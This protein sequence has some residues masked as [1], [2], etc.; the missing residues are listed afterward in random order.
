[1]FP[2]RVG[3]AR[4]K[5]RLVAVFAIALVAVR[6]APA[7]AGA[8]V[9]IGGT[10]GFPYYPYPGYGYYPYPYAYPYPYPY[11]TEAAPPPGYDPGHWERRYDP[12]GREYWAWVPSHLR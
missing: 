9:F 7:V 11:Y 1:V 5:A 8:H 10:F 3:A 2:R 12:W 6:A 4:W